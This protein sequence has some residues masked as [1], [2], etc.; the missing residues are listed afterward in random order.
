M[1][2][3]V[4]AATDCTFYEITPA[5]ELIRELWFKSPY[6]CMMHDFAIRRTTRLFHIVPS[7]GSWNG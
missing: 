1:P 4:C 7:I 6:Y 3:P 2:R 5:G